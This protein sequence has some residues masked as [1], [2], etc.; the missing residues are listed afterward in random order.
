MKHIAIGLFALFCLQLPNLGS[1][2]HLL[3][4]VASHQLTLS[5]EVI[6][7]DGNN[8]YVLFFQSNVSQQAVT[9]FLDTY[10]PDATFC[11]AS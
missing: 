1:L 3:Q 2:N 7:C 4:A 5:H 8:G 11:P 6:T 10:Q 9:L